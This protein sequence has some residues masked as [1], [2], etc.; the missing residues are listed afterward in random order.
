MN[1][2][3]VRTELQMQ[4]ALCLRPKAIMFVMALVAA[5][6]GAWRAGGE[7]LQSAI[8]RTVLLRTRRAS[9]YNP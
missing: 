6:V 1:E 9:I 4:A 3:E 8:T 5:T 2:C 7:G